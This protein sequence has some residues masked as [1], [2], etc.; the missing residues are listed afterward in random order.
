MFVVRLTPKDGKPDFKAFGGLA[1]ARARFEAAW[2]PT[3]GIDALESAVLFN[4]P[5]EGDARRAVE[6]VKAGL[7]E[8]VERDNWRELRGFTLDDML[9]SGATA[10]DTPDA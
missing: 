8:I 9:G 10:K 7:A 1:A 5:N 6:A 4:V 2:G 3:Y